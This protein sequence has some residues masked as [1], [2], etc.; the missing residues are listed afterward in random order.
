MF[1]HLWLM[2]A[3]AGGD[4]LWTLSRGLAR[5]VHSYKG[6]LDNADNK[7]RH[8][9]DGRVY[10]SQAALGE[11]CDFMLDCANDQIDYMKDMLDLPLLTKRIRGYCKVKEQSEDLPKRSSLILPEIA[12]KG[13]IA[14]GEVARIIDASP[15]TA[16][17][18][19]G[20]LLQRGY[21]KSDSPKGNLYIGFPSEACAYFFPQLF[22]TGITDHTP[23]LGGGGLSIRRAISSDKKDAEMEDSPSLE[24]PS[25]NQL[26]TQQ[27]SDMGKGGFA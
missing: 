2:K 13:E 27:A 12:L 18:V 19:T 10:L 22:P 9:T 11:F 1:T 7:R 16:Q 17:A 24:G 15:R 26:S 3:G 5:N 14:R 8:D 25:G 6:L 20:D 4:G 23:Q 21:L